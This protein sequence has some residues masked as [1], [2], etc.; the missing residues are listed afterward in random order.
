[1]VLMEVRTSSG[2][3]RRCDKRCYE[4][5]H[6]KC[7]CIC[8]GKNHGVGLQKAMENVRE[9]A[10]KM[11]ERASVNGETTMRVANYIK[12]MIE[13]GELFAIQNQ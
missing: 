10:L 6:K 2:G 12:E 11:I 9:D 7:T 8:G 1:M 3:V 4:A 5:K 13:Q